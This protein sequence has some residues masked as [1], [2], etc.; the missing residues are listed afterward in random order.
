MGVQGNIEY[1]AVE[2]AYV[3]KFGFG[4]K[5][6]DVEPNIK[7]QLYVRPEFGTSLTHKTSYSKS[8]AVYRGVHPSMVEWS[9]V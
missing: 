2:C 1:H 3:P 9:E 6:N 7:R 4:K 5:G 8:Y